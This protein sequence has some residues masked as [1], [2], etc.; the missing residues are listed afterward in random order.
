MSCTLAGK[1]C[2]VTGA[3]SGI[4]E[5]VALEFAACGA[6][7]SLTGRNVERGHSVLEQV[8]ARGAADAIFMQA[9]VTDPDAVSRVVRETVDHF[10]RIDVLF[11]NAGIID[12]GSVDEIPV[13]RFR[14]VIE[15]NLIGQFNFAH[16]VVPVM[17]RQGG[18]S[19]VNMASDWGLVAGP[20]SVAYC[21]SKGGVIMLSK[22]IALDHAADG[23]RCNAICPG[24]TIT[25]M[26]DFRAEFDDHT[27]EEQESIYA[28]A[29]P[30]GRMARPEEIAK[31]VAFLASEDSS[32]VTGVAMP[33]DGGNT[34]Q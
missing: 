5:A 19:I 14:R 21:A 34:C 2:L 22:A 11:N 6:A 3:T 7:L 27:A 8:R 13:E 17:K 12:T 28:S 20:N 4:G 23:I 9:D 33:V 31:V 15:V 32:F 16:E 30:L 24:D 29:L 10:K 25:P 18:G 1:V 26:H